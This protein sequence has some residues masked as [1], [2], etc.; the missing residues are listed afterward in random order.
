[1]FRDEHPQQLPMP[2]VI[3]NACTRKRKGLAIACLLFALLSIPLLPLG[4]LTSLLSL[5]LG[6]TSLAKLSKHPDRY[7]G[8]AITIV[9]MVLSGNYILF[10]GRILLNAVASRF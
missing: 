4:I 6:V 8:L 5:V 3:D 2:A 10:M 9:G 7:G 1:M